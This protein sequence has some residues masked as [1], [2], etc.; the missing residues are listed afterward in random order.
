M[1]NAEATKRLRG[2]NA[3]RRYI[4]KT[5]VF[6]IRNGDVQIVNRQNL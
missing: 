2:L 4:D 3:Q 1:G 6:L 5:I